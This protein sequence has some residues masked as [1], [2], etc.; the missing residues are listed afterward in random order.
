SGNVGAVGAGGRARLT[1]AVR[2]SGTTAS[3]AEANAT[4]SDSA[5]TTA[6]ATAQATVTGHTCTIS[7]TKAP[8]TTDVC[9]GTN[10][11]V[12]Y[13]YVVTNTGDFFN[14]S[15]SVSDDVVGSIGNFWPLAPAAS[16]TLT[17]AAP[18]T[19]TTTNLPYATVLRTDSASTTAQATAQ[20]TVT[21][22]TCTI[23]LTKAPSPT[24]VCNGTNTSVTYTYVVT[25]T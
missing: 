5:S 10:T 7:L 20:A 16:A 9:N 21:G 22:H 15:G 12:T 23:S 6:Q 14:A 1:K 17:K 18:I 19:G 4:F 13:T 3:P 2:D 8:S 24:D 25:N 11:S